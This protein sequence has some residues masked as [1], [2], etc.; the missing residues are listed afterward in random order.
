MKRSLKEDGRGERGKR[1]D[2]FLANER[3]STE[4]VVLA[5]AMKIDQKVSET[6]RR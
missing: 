1:S 4:K 6:N 5:L 3:E 2:A